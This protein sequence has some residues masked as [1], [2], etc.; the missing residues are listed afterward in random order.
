MAGKVS[1]DIIRNNLVLYLDATNTKS[2]TSGSSTWFDL[3]GNNNNSVLTNGPTFSTTNGGGIT[4]DGTDDY[5]S[6]LDNNILRPT[7]FT[8]DV[9]FRPTSFSTYNTLVVKPVNGPVWS[10]P[11]LSYMI[12]IQSNGTLLQCGTNNG[13]YQT[14]D[15]SLTFTA[16]INY[17]I[18]FTYDSSNRIATAYRNGIQVNTTTFTAGSITYGTS[19]LLI[20]A[21]YGTSPTGEHFAGSIFNVKMYNKVLTATEVLQNYNTTKTR[22]GL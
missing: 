14:L 16:N 6:S 3:S 13:L 7:T 1:L 12:R 8:I 21:G 15:T 19:P 17:N 11:Y 18:T 5:I 2:Y 20:G 10:S 9:W 4:F 22:F